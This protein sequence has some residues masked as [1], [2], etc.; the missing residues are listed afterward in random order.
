MLF[1]GFEP[2]LL[3]AEKIV[4]LSPMENYVLGGLLFL[5]VKSS[6]FLV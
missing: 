5:K 4:F 6:S 3:I 1:F 2:F